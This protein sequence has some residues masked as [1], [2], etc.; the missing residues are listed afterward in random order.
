MDASVS[1]IVLARFPVRFW[2]AA[3]L[4]DM[5]AGMAIIIAIEKPNAITTRRAL[6]FR[7][8]MFLN[9]LVITH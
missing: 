6:I 9:A 3:W 2:V 4:A 7:L 1:V 8:D 5:P